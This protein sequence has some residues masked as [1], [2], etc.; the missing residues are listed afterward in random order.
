MAE[1]LDLRATQERFL[2]LVTAADGVEGAAARLGVGEA[3]LL[4][5][6]RSDAR[7]DA[8]GRLGVYAEMYAARLEDA[9]AEDYPKLAAA[10]GEEAFAELLADFLA[11][12]PPH[13]Y[14]LRH[15]G[16]PLAGF[17]ARHALAARR[18]WLV[19]LAAL[20]WARVEM[21]DR[22]DAEVLTLDDLRALSPER[23]AELPLRAVPALTVLSLAAGVDEIWRQ[24]EA[25]DERP[26][27]RGAGSG[28]GAGA[29]RSGAR[30]DV[31]VWRR[32]IDVYHR[33][34]T[35]PE[36]EALPLL[37]AGTTLGR[38]GERLGEG[39]SEEQ[40]ARLTFELVGSWARDG[41]VV[42]PSEA[43]RGSP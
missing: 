21:F 19:D 11:A 42:R 36:A 22:A 9:L 37:T 31:V 10:C 41:L 20:E 15:L 17:L 14:S 38:V 4:A 40:A 23:F 18:P 5:L 24:I 30:Q 1:R 13:D 26:T 12:S 34:A 33:A 3:E 27:W 43:G 8:G 7:L 39:R 16:A 6:V 35:G 32:D 29:R 25:G 2:A 28:E